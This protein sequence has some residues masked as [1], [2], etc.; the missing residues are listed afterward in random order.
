MSY[1]NHAMREFQAA[2]WLDEKGEFKCS[3]Q[4]LVCEQVLHLLE[5]FSS[6]G[7]SGSSAPDAIELF[8]KLAKF[9]PVVPIMGTDDEWQ[10]VG[11]GVYQNK[12]CGHVFKQADR[13]NG[14]AYDIEAVIFWEWFTPKDG[15]EPFKSYFTSGDSCRPITFPYTPTRVYEER[16]N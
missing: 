4:K 11:E 5:V 12:R 8:S 14:Q 13:F 6:H 7:H 3:M 2:G 1:K 15:G 16:K 10:E 9:E